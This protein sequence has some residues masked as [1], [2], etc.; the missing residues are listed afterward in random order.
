MAGFNVSM[1]DDML[2]KYNFKEDEL[3]N[4][5]TEASPI[6]EDA[7]KRTIQSV[8]GHGGDSVLVNSIK[9][10]RPKRTKTDAII[11]WVGPSGTDKKGRKKSI[12]NIEKAIYL[13]YGTVKQP[14]RPWLAKSIN[15]SESL[16]QNKLQETLEER[17]KQ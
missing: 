4:A 13:N 9:V 1:P 3:V 2:E 10:S 12:R 15:E 5:V 11:S 16:I 14:A 7:M 17:W 6:L 8:I